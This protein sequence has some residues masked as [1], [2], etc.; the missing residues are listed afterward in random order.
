[1]NLVSVIVPIYNVS[2]FIEKCVTSLLTQTYEKIEIILVD[3]G[4]PDDCPAICDA[5]A[6]RDARVRVIHQHNGGLSAARNTGIQAAKGAYLAFVDGDD[7]V[8]PDYI[9]TLLNACEENHTKMAACGYIEYYSEERR[10]VVCVDEPVV[11]SAEEAITDIFTMSNQVQV[12]AWNKLYAREL[13]DTTDIRYPVGKIHEDVFTTYRYCAAAG[14]IACVN[15]PCYYYVQREGS[16]ISQ[17]FSPAKRLQ[18]LDAVSSIQPFVESHTPIY[19][20][21]YAYYVFL[22]C[23]TIINAMADSRYYDKQLFNEMRGRIR[24]HFSDLRKNRY[25]SS[26]NRLTCFLLTLG[27]RG[28][29]VFRK[30]YKG[31]R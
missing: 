10:T 30:L 12:M 23:L 28:Y 6:A 27:M 13:F 22:N 31:C 11:L 2:Q 19:D 18:L 5:F 4:S 24:E 25:F 17:T 3:D 15:K 8:S 9:E 20:E 21:A 1:M 16:I 7:F 26:K 14:K 29:Y